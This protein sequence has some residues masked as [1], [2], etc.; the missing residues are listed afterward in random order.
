MEDCVDHHFKNIQQPK[1]SRIDKNRSTRCDMVTPIFIRIT[2]NITF[3]IA[4][5]HD[6]KHIKISVRWKSW[7]ATIHFFLDATGL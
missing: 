2:E 3:A 6:T 7:C 5:M 4:I 1:P